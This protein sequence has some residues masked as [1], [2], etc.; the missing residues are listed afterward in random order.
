QEGGASL[1]AHLEP[2]KKL[3]GP[4]SRGDVDPAFITA[5]PGFEPAV[6]R[7]R[8]LLPDRRWFLDRGRRDEQKHLR[9]P[10]VVYQADVPEAVQAV[11]RGQGSMKVWTLFLSDPRFR[12]QSRRGVRGGAGRPGV[13]DHGL[14]ALTP[15]IGRGLR[16]K[17]SASNHQEHRHGPLPTNI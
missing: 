6:S 13:E 7:G 14:D 9:G 1:A 4:D 15:S 16:A 5:A 17:K 12:N 8:D 10:R 11:E 2:G 3:P